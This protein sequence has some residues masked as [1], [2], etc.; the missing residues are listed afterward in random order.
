[1][2]VDKLLTFTGASG[3]AITSA[4]TTAT[5]DHIDTAPLGGNLGRNLGTGQRMELVLSIRA[6]SVTTVTTPTAQVIIQTDD[7]SS[8]SS[9]TTLL[10][11]A[12]VA[13]PTTSG[14]LAGN[15]IKQLL[16]IPLPLTN[17]YERYVRCQIVTG[18]TITTASYT[19]DLSIVEAADAWVAKADAIDV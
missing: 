19:F 17:S 12:A 4:A 16:V 3:Q 6:G 5:T 7:N 9:A 15:D 1:M 2:I 11:S 14:T 10:T 8:F 13:L 18:G